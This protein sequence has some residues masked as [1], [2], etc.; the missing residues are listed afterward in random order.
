MRSVQFPAV[1]S[2]RIWGKPLFLFWYANGQTHNDEWVMCG[3]CAE[4]PKGRYF[5]ESI[6]L[7]P[8]NP[9]FIR[10]QRVRIKED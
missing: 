4:N 9:M 10:Y 1:F 8:T 7:V 2:R 3:E 6:C 5:M